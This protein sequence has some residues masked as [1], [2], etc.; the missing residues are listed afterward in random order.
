M[1]RH[2]AYFLQSSYPAVYAAFSGVTYSDF[3]FCCSG[4]FLQYI[5]SDKNSVAVWPLLKKRFSRLYPLHLATTLFYVGILLIS[6]YVGAL[7]ST[8]S[9][10][11]CVIPTVTLTHAFGTLD[12]ECLNYPSW[13][14]SALFALYIAYP[15][16]WLLM[17]KAGVGAFVVIIVLVVAVYEAAYY[18]GDYP[19][20]TTLT[21]NFGILR[22]IPTFL[23]GMVIAEMLPAIKTRVAGFYWAYAAFA[24]SLVG[25][26]IGIDPLISQEILPVAVVALLASA[27]AGGADSFLRA[28]MLVPVGT[29]SFPLYLLHVPVAAVI[30]NFLFVRILHVSGLVSIIAA[31]ITAVVAV[32]LSYVAHR[33]LDE[34]V[35]RW[36]SRRIQSPT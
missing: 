33:M 17:R 7:G 18:L 34:W 25:M 4:F 35:P 16:L 15:T 30:M 23:A 28:P 32:A 2:Y 24:A 14:L 5:N 10:W 13:F 22:G 19:H 11:D 31:L 20:W 26:M 1:A 27:E 29:W 12:R 6:A 9:G 36:R 8:R 3:F 21:H